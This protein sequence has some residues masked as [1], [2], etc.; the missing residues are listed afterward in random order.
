M[1]I[2]NSHLFPY[3]ALDVS[4]FLLEM[5]SPRALDLKEF[6]TW[7]HVAA[8]TQ[9][10][11]PRWLLML[12]EKEQS[13]LTRANDGSH[14][15]KRAYD[16]TLGYG[17]E[18]GGDLPDPGLIG[19]R[20][21][22]YR[23]ARGLRGYLTRGQ[24]LYVGGMVGHEQMGTEGSFTPRTLAEA[25]GWQYTPWAKNMKDILSVWDRLKAYGPK[26]WA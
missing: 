20:N 23:A 15:W 9:D 22:V 3:K 4:A 5:H 14:G 18:D 21:Q 1:M 13:F 16:W 26:A 25:A 7:V 11:N 12:A 24:P 2:P 8:E 17:A 19:P 10:I 6:H